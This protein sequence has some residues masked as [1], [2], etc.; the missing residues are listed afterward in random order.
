MNEFYQ[1]K[2]KKTERKSSISYLNLICC[3]NEVRHEA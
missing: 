3:P 1:N 2:N